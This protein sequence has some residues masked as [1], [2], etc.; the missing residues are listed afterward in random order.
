MKMTAGSE[1]CGSID[2]VESRERG[3]EGRE[4]VGNESEAVGV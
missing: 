1:D 2:G 3:T 4:V